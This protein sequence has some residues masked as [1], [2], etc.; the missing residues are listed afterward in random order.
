MAEGTDRGFS[1]KRVKCDLMQVVR[2]LGWSGKD[3]LLDADEPASWSVRMLRASADSDKRN[4]VF[5]ERAGNP[6]L[7]FRL[8]IRERF[9]SELEKKTDA[10]A[11]KVRGVKGQGEGCDPI[12]PEEGKTK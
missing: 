4:L 1:R 11:R 9:S 7:W 2:C 12:Y 3:T 5:A 6:E 10:P 8:V